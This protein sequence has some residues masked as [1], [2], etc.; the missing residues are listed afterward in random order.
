MLI[1][2]W[3]PVM[4][5]NT[6]LTMRLTVQCHRDPEGDKG[7]FPYIEISSR[8]TSYL[9][10]LHPRGHTPMSKEGLACVG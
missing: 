6:V 8:R 1:A 9:I 5:V 2:Q 3:M 10:P 4:M 7:P